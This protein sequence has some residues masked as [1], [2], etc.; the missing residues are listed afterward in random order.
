MR[1]PLAALADVRTPQEAIARFKTM[2]PQR[3]MQLIAM[4]MR[5]GDARRGR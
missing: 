2:D 3:R 1:T 5:V 4:F